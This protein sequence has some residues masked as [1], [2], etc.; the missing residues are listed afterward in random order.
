MVK[1]CVSKY[2]IEKVKLKLNLGNALILHLILMKKDPI[3]INFLFL[4]IIGIK[5]IMSKKLKLK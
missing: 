3:A 2:R 1:N 5:E 4:S